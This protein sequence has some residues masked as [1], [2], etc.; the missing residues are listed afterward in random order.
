MI[1]TIVSC[2]LHSAEESPTRIVAIGILTVIAIL[3]IF[4][5]ERADADTVVFRNPVVRIEEEVYTFKSPDNGSGPLWSYGC[6][7]IVRMGEEVVVSAM[8][9]G[10][11]VPPLCNTRWRL[12]RR[13]QGAWRM[14]AEAD[15]YR[16]R[17]PCPVAITSDQDLFLYVNDS[18]E[19]PGTYYGPC[20]PHLIHFQMQ[21]SG[22]ARTALRPQWAGKPYYTDHSYRGYAADPARGELLMLNID[23]K[24]GVQHACLLNTNG[25]T[26]ATGSIEFPIRSCYPQVALVDRAA[27]VLAIGDIV[28]PV[29]EWREYKFEQTQREWDYVFRILYFTWTPDITSQ[30]FAAP[31]EIANVDASGGHISNQDLWIAPDGAAWL[32]Y[33]ERE[34]QNELMR[35]RFFPDKSVINSLHLAVVKN[36][37]IIERRVLMEGSASEAPGHARFHSTPDGQLYVVAYCRGENAGHRLLRLL[38]ES[39]RLQAIPLPL[40]RPM[41]EYCL[42]SVRAGNASAFIIDMLG[43]SSENTLSY[44]RIDLE[45]AS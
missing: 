6:T 44:A 31:I 38:P 29:K 4:A 24:T 32:M 33:T 22:I 37:E 28:E 13:E 2:L 5:S 1:K 11:D 14:I 40:K 21:E 9:T 10:V 20:D 17:E 43:L 45:P 18:L 25:D 39:N 30:P 15:A 36:S 26:L 3:S 41:S 7:Q 8:E 42:A 35:D 16:Q 34:V 23:A 27:Y 19:P 12:L